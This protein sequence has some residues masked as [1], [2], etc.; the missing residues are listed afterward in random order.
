MNAVAVHTTRPIRSQKTGLILPRTGRLVEERE[1]LGRKMYLIRFS[2]TATEYLFEGEFEE[3]K[4][5]A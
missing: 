3:E 2:E 4:A 5:C 1:Q